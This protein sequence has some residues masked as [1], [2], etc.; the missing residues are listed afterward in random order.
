MSLTLKELN[1]LVEDTSRHDPFRNWSQRN[2]QMFYR[3]LYVK[4]DPQLADIKAMY[5]RKFERLKNIY[6]STRQ[7]MGG[8]TF[9]PGK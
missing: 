6:D 5:E 3:S 2:D 1:Q 4:H 8:W 9:R 7:G